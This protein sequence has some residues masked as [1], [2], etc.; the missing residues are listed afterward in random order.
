MRKIS[1]FA[2]IFLLAV[3]LTGCDALQRKFTR[4]KKETKP[5]PRLYQLKKYDVKPS[6]ALYSK[7]YAYWQSWMSELIQDLGDNHK[8]D[9]RCIDEALSQLHDM[10]NILVQEKADALTKHI[11]RIEKS[12]EIIIKE[13]LSQ[14]NKNQVLMTLER[15]DRI[16]KSEFTVSRIKNDIKE[17]FDETP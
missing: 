1:V 8:K 14:Y 9:V 11:R 12:R 3:T 6:A 7:H 13:G 17:S 4:K 2:M 5:I 10:R 16:V 15:E